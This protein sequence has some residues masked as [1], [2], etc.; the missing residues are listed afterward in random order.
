MRTRGARRSD[1]RLKT[2]RTWSCAE[3]RLSATESLSGSSSRARKRSKRRPKSPQSEFLRS[4]AVNLTRPAS[5]AVLA[6][7]L[8]AAT[9]VF[10]MVAASR[11]GISQFP[12]VDFRI[13]ACRSPGGRGTEVVE[14]D[15][16]EI[17]EEALVQSR[18]CARSRPTADGLGL[19]YPGARHLQGRG[20]A[21]Q[22]VQA[23]CRRRREGC[24]A[25]S[26]RRSSPRATRGPADH[27]HLAGRAFR[28]GC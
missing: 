18:A 7:M 28:C 15:V 11:I 6:W 1:V 20:F 4:S 26:T 17:L 21:L 13:S 5:E 14:N 8:M 19:H 24:R 27:I 25:T 3:A 12:D 22:D 16:V 23:R 9:I 2:A 10:G